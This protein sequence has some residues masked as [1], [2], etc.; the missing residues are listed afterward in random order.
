MLRSCNWSVLLW[1]VLHCY[2]VAYSFMHYI[3][4]S[5]FP[6]L[7]V[8]TNWPFCVYVSLN[9]NQSINQ[10]CLPQSPRI[11]I[12]L[13][14]RDFRHAG[15]SFWNSLPHHLRSI[16]SCA[17]FKFNLKLT[18]SLMQA[19]E[20][21]NNSILALL[22]SHNHV[23]FCALNYIMLCYSKACPLPL[24]TLASKLLLQ[25]FA[26][27]PSLT[28]ALT[29][30][31]RCNI[32]LFRMQWTCNYVHSINETQITVTHNITHNATQLH[33][34]NIFNRNLAHHVQRAG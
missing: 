1:T 25:S 23:D 11:N 26:I 20:A 30:I 6:A 17:V 12:A 24:Y 34:C 5:R 2:R 19:F 28:T 21:P 3:S 7:T 14:S 4:L 31:W 9:T 8:G 16:D 13:A 29:E 15:P 22:F 33:S 27:L 10:L 18:F 32:I